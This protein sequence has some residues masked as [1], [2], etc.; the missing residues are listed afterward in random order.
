MIGN[1]ITARNLS[2]VPCTGRVAFHRNPFFQRQVRAAVERRR[3]GKWFMHVRDGS[4]SVKTLP[5]SKTL[6]R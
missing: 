6:P 3:P 4:Q 5:H 2:Y 1:E